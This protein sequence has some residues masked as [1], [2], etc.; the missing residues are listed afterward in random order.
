MEHDTRRLHAMTPGL[1]GQTIDRAGGSKTD[2]PR[3]W[4][5]QTPAADCG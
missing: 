3:L 5:P 1:V 2:A 4:R